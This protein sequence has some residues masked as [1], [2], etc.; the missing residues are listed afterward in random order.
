M[1]RMRIAALACAMAGVMAI[2]ATTSMTEAA[3]S[4]NFNL[5]TEF[6]FTVEEVD[7]QAPKFILQHSVDGNTYASTDASGKAETLELTFDAAALALKPGEDN[8]VYAPMF[9]RLGAGTTN[10]ANATLTENQLVDAAFPNSLRA[11]IYK[12]VESCSADGVAGKTTIHTSENLRGQTTNVFELK[13]PEAGGPGETV[14]L[15]VEA[16]MDNNNWLLGGAKTE[17]VTARWQV[18]AE[19]KEQ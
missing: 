17:P 11:R 9:V 4:Q 19:E 10:D 16:W 13:A 1:Q 8:A 14:K 5:T 2:G 7:D 6:K 18:R 3:R 15:C 12:D